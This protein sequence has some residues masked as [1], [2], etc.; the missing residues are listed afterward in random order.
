MGKLRSNVFGTTFFVYDSGKKED[1]GN[2]RLDLAV[3]IYVSN[4]NR[5]KVCFLATGTQWNKFQKY[6]V[7]NTFF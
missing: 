5:V 1:H 2:P 6:M 3:V 4:F 7:K